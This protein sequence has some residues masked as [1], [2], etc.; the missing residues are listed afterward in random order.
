MANNEIQFDLSEIKTVV[1]EI[2]SLTNQIGPMRLTDHMRSKL[3]AIAADCQ[4]AIDVE[5]LTFSF[6]EPCTV[7]PSGEM[8]SILA[9]LRALASL[10]ESK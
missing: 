1:D 3:F 2:V 4:K 6:K 9:T 8:L 10:K 7:Q 5:S